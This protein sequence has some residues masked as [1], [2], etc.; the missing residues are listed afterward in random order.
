MAD[1]A[2]ITGI[3]YQN[4][5]ASD[6]K[7][8]WAN[9]KMIFEPRLLDETTYIVDSKSAVTVVSG[10]DGNITA[11]LW[12]GKWVVTMPDNESFEIIVTATNYTLIDLRGL[13]SGPTTNVLTL[14]VPSGANSGDIL[15]WGV[16][17]LQWVPQITISE[18]SGVL[19]I[20]R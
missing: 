3:L 9:A 7:T 10:S 1:L 16:S 12:P 6:T 2:T 8:V 19:T 20:T 14:I 13:V 17:G 5:N 15:S 11:Y 18:T 4:T